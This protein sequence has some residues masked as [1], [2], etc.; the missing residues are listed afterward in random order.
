MPYEEV[1]E[2]ESVREPRPPAKYPNAKKVFRLFRN[3]PVIWSVNRQMLSAAE[4]LY[5][6]KGMEELSE[7]M[8]WYESH[9]EEKF[10]PHFN[11]PME[12]AVK[13]H[14]LEEHLVRTT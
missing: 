3:Y 7:L 6:E 11:D 2:F 14:K 9:K 8:D 12:L 1:S 13:Y 10:C 5:Q 4:F